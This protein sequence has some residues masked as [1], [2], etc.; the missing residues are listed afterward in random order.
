[1]EGNQLKE[2]TGEKYL[3]NT[4]LTQID[5]NYEN[6]KRLR[7][8]LNSF[9]ALYKED[10]SNLM[11]LEYAILL[12]DLI[13]RNKFRIEYYI[14]YKGENKG[15][16]DR[17]EGIHKNSSV[18]QGQKIID[19]LGHLVSHKDIFKLINKYNYGKIIYNRNNYQI[20]KA[21]GYYAG[22]NK[23]IMRYKV[24]YVKMDESNCSIKGND[25]YE[26]TCIVFNSIK[27]LITYVENERA[28][29]PDINKVTETLE[30]KLGL[31]NYK[32]E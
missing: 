25:W 8:S 27:D 23:A 6:A 13:I 29:D 17:A 18:S 31:L 26:D 19:Q 12:E 24:D 30:F 2:K 15:R 7:S 20:G 10:N 32:G 5:H 3:M 1:M 9:Y 16:I 4:L 28:T 14:P 11:A 22:N 21:K